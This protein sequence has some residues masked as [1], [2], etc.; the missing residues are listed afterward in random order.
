M[1]GILFLFNIYNYK[2]LGGSFWGSCKNFGKKRS[3][4][5]IGIHKVKGAKE[6]IGYTLDNNETEEHI[7]TTVSKWLQSLADRP[8]IRRRFCWI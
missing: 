3:Q 5:F 8:E 6:K 2:F 7:E 4:V 1:P